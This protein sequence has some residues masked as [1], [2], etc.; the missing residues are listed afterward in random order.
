MGLSVCWS[1]P[2][3][4]GSRGRIWFACRP[5]AIATLHITFQKILRHKNGL[6]A[7]PDLA[8]EAVVGN[9]LGQ[10]AIRTFFAVVAGKRDMPFSSLLKH[11]C[12]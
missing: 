7:E 5:G 8:L 2:N 12:L 10:D 4:G 11:I 3:Q 6:Q 9:C 1:D